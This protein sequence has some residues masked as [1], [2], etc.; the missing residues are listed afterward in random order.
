[1]SLNLCALSFLACHP[2]AGPVS[3]VFP[4]HQEQTR[5]GFS[6]GHTGR[7][8]FQGRTH[9]AA[10]CLTEDHWLVLFVL[11]FF[12]SELHSFYCSSTSSFH[13]RSFQ[14]EKGVLLLMSPDS[15]MSVGI[16]NFLFGYFLFLEN[17]FHSVRTLLWVI[18]EHITGSS[19]LKLL[20][21]SV[22]A[23]INELY[24]VKLITSLMHTRKAN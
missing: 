23:I 6:S 16:I 22:A 1:M 17:L 9:C 13:W 5:S 24:T 19:Q 12:L 4:V 7:W 21:L 2:T 15:N 11:R 3:A 14:R 10:C 18:F 8:L 20:Y